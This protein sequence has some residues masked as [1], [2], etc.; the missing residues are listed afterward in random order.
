L[1]RIFVDT[2]LFIRYLINDVPS[3]VDKIERLFDLAEKR[4]VTLVTGPPVFFEI[5]WTLK[6]FYN[7]NRKRIYE[8]LSGILGLPGL[9]VTD[10]DILEEALELYHHTSTDFSDAYVA[11][12]SKKVGA[13]SIATFNEKHFKNLDVQIHPLEK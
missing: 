4:D 12:L 5:A 10:L 1:K 7:M 8:C 13:N 11:V 3:Q 6:S 2:N 9:E